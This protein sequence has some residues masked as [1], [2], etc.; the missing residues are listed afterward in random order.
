MHRVIAVELESEILDALE[1]CAPSWKIEI[2]PT[3]EENG[4]RAITD[5]TDEILLVMMGGRVEDPVRLVRH[6][7]LHAPELP[8]VYFGDGDACRDVRGRL[9]YDPFVGRDTWCITARNPREVTRE[10]SHL[11]QRARRK[12]D[13]VET[14]AALN[15]RLATSN[16]SPAPLRITPLRRLLET[17]PVGVALLGPK[18]EIEAINPAL[19]ALFRRAP[20]D[21]VGRSVFDL[22]DGKS[23]NDLRAFMRLTLGGEEPSPQVVS[24]NLDRRRRH[25]E[26]TG[27]RIESDDAARG[28]LLI[29][30]DVSDRV[31][32]CLEL[33]SAN[34]RKDEFIAMLGH[35]LRNPLAPIRTAL[36]L[37]QL[38]DEH[39][40]ARERE[41]V[42]RQVD[43]LVE[44]VDD[45]LDVSRINKG[46]LE[47]RKSL[48]ETSE[49]VEDAIERARDLIER[50]QHRLDVN[51]P[52][53]GLPVHG[54][55]GR[56][57]QVVA[58]L[59]TNAAR[60][61]DPGGMISVSGEGRGNRVLLRV[62]D[63][64]RGIPEEMLPVIFG[65]YVQAD[66]TVERESGGLGLGL[67]IVR[68]IVDSHGGSVR[69]RSRVG[70]GT[71]FEVELPLANSPERG[72]G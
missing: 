22:V 32:L 54:D 44:L 17:L 56:L 67:A 16:G 53:R 38:K 41:I 14:V 66:R 26:V 71:E 60:Y 49:F 27:S 12:R 19:S 33:Q 55:R 15:R 61:T 7:Y 3:D 64:G 4:L 2:E 35:E 11:V 72:A 63:T 70:E 39:T 62:R 68:S 1:A 52:P 48:V 50:R 29:F 6:A 13:L 30:Q 59:L 23:V 47:I 43:H 10:T 37:M 20:R 57:S 45:L 25:L 28:L 21:I 18:G 42:R 31:E 9:R 34:D 51:V 69:V 36:E 8:I 58:N 24:T 46:K 65:S 40:F 5:C